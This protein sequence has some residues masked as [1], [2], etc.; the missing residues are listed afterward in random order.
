MTPKPTRVL[1]ANEDLPSRRGL[2]IALGAEGYYVEEVA[3][4]EETERALAEQAADLVLL[5]FHT[6]EASGHEMCRRIRLIRPAAAVVIA[7]FRDA[8]EDAI[9]ALEA[10]ADDY[11]IKPYRVRELLARISAILRRGRDGAATGASVLRAGRLELDTV[12]RTLRKDGEEVRLSPIEFD[13]LQYLMRHAEVLVEHSKLLRAIWGPEYGSEL[14]YL[15][16][17]IRLIRKKIEDN[18]KQPA[19]ILTEPW[20]GYRF[21]DPLRVRGAPAAL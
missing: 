3:T 17:Y 1:L 6:P 19:Y 8:E 18:P 10:G 7:S 11:I 4:A 21:R 5:D 16:T 14:E 13:I 9:D 20:V 15:R 12:R 2:S